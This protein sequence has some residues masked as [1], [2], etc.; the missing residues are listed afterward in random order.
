MVVFWEPNLGPLQEQP[1]LSMAES[2]LQPG[3]HCLCLKSTISFPAML[4]LLQFSSSSRELPGLISVCLISTDFEVSKFTFTE[5]LTLTV[6]STVHPDHITLLLVPFP[7]S[8]VLHF[9]KL[10]FF[11]LNVLILVSL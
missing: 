2:S 9:H 5:E 11:N 4:A 7:S 3:P 1:V 10:Y 8:R 6:I